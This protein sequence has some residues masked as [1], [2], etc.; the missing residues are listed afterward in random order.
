MLQIMLVGLFTSHAE[1][2]GLKVGFYKKSC[3]QAEAIVSKVISDVMAVAP[4]LS[5]PLLRMHFHDCF[6]RVRNITSYLKILVIYF[7]H[8]YICINK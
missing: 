8:L 6:I 2:Q 1:G 4:S 3:P 7:E 5:G